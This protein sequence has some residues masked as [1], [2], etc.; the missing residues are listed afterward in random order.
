M[1]AA[2]YTST[3]DVMCEQYAACNLLALS[4]S[5]CS[6]CATLEHCH[7]C[8]TCSMSNCLLELALF[9]AKDLIAVKYCM[10]HIVHMVTEGLCHRCCATVVAATDAAA[11]TI[12]VCF[13]DDC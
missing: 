11:A 8:L 2:V 6:D 9:G 12:T 13:D 1:A 3:D 10:Q 7:C 4:S 5:T